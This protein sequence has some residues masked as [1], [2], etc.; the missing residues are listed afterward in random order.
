MDQEKNTDGYKRRKFNIGHLNLMEQV[1]MILVI[2]S[3]TQ[4][5]ERQ[6]ESNQAQN[7][8]CPLPCPPLHLGT[9]KPDHG[10]QA[11]ASSTLIIT[12]MRN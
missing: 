12:I 7:K 9:W 11:A 10:D 8:Q 2:P 4:P 5:E 1:D 6:S 3:G